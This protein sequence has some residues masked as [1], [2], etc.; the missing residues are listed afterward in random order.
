MA[1]VDRQMLM[2]YVN[3]FAQAL[4]AHQ[5]RD[6]PMP[7]S[8]VNLTYMQDMHQ[9]TM[10][11]VQNNQEVLGQFLNQHPTMTPETV[12]RL[13]NE[14]VLRRHGFQGF[15]Q[16]Q[17]PPPASVIPVRPVMRRQT[18]A[19]DFRETSAPK[20]QPSRAPLAIARPHTQAWN[21]RETFAP[22]APPARAPPARAQ[23]SR[24]PPAIAPSQYAA[25][26]A[27]GQ[28]AGPLPKARSVAGPIP[29]N[30]ILRQYTPGTQAAPIRE[31]LGPK[32]KYTK[33]PQVRKP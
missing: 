15:G 27:A 31:P 25:P 32:S 2:G 16:G 29:R 18:Q 10:Q 11:V 13:V 20:A 22:S 19:W 28:S 33:N 4:H 3:Q 1:A 21:F 30:P 26:V 23:P 8:E 17:P 14:D 9:Q 12:I 6:E 7:Q 24:A 5:N